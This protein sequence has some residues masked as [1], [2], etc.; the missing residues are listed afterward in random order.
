MTDS[1]G[2]KF[3][4]IYYMVFDRKFAN[5]WASLM[6]QTAK[7]LLTKQKT[8]VWCLGSEDAL[9]KG[10]YSLQYSC[11]ENS[12]NRRAWWATIQGISRLEKTEWL[13]LSHLPT[14]DLRIKELKKRRIKGLKFP[15]N[16]RA[17]TLCS[18]CWGYVFNP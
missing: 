15:T 12:M 14:S 2:W 11:L 9:E 7:S 5:L 16:P 3:S 10:I 8:W 1:Q 13:T 17:K 6:A 4:N 18:H